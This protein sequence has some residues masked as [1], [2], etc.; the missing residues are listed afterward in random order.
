[1]S[2]SPISLLPILREAPLTP[3][4]PNYWKPQV[5]KRPS[6]RLSPATFYNTSN[7]PYSAQIQ[8]STWNHAILLHS[9]PGY[10]WSFRQSLAHWA[11]TQA[12]TISPPQLIPHS[13]ILSA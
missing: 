13:Q 9:L 4:P 6:V 7:S 5:T 10:L 3:P 2:Y 11:P 1:M 8:R 12:T